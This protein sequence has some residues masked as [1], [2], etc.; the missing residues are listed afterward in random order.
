MD[1]IKKEVQKTLAKSPNFLETLDLE[2]TYTL[3]GSAGS[4]NCRLPTLL[5]FD[6]RFVFSAVASCT[7]LCGG[8]LKIFW[9]ELAQPSCFLPNLAGA[10]VHGT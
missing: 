3:F 1:I 5:L 8:N 10:E 4:A 2:T 7:P 6:Y 9:F